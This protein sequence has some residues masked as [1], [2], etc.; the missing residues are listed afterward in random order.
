[1]AGGRTARSLRAR[2]RCVSDASLPL[3]AACQIGCSL[4]LRESRTCATSAEISPGVSGWSLNGDDACCRPDGDRGGLHPAAPGGLLIRGETLSDGVYGP[5]GVVGDVGATDHAVG[6]KIESGDDAR[7][8]GDI[9]G[10]RA[11][12]FA[13]AAAAA[14]AAA[15]SAATES[16]SNASRERARAAMLT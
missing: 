15:A 6:V 11:T 2:S 9:R 5:T 4:N 7:S 14:S 1:M 8:R 3:A 12:E 13:A 16:M 10:D